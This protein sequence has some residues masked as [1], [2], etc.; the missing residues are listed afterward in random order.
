LRGLAFGNPKLSKL[1]GVRF[2]DVDI[3]EFMID[4]VPQNLEYRE[5]NN[6]T[7]KDFL[8]L[9]V[10][11]RNTG[12]VQADGDWETKITH[13]E[14]KKTLSIQEVAA[15]SFIFLLAGFETSSTTM[16]YCLYELARNPVY[17]RKVQDEIKDVLEKHDGRITYE[18]VSEMQFL[19]NCI[20][21]T[22]RLY[23]P[24]LI[25]NRECTKDWEIPDTGV[26]IKKG[27]QVVIPAY[28][29]QRDEK[30]YPNPNEFIPERFNAENSL[31]K[32]FVDRP[33]MPFGEGPRLCIGLRLGKMQSKVG[34][35]LMLKNYNFELT[36]ST[37]KPLVI[38]P[39]SFIVAPIGGLPLKVTKR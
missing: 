23:P 28:A 27:V 6:V 21:E 16:S 4:T 7:R 38:N 3:G 11:L 32:T 13:D 34:L 9:M 26:V 20:D 2:T 39:S 17:Q 25:L 8:Q 33:Y 35:L 30:Y 10:Q 24:L 14:S 36:G 31:G 22:L 19:E 1:F 5:K 29:L 18:S 15:Q 12:A 37:L